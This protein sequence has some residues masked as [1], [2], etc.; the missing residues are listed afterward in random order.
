MIGRSLLGFSL[1]I[2]ASTALAQTPGPGASGVEGVIQ[3]SPSRP[4]PFRK[5]APNTAPAGNL[6]F[7]VRKSEVRV[8]SFATDAEGRF[9]VSLPPGH[10]E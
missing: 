10:Y 7:V 5:D 6:E 3:V 8:A 1:A 2:V 9:R 4:G